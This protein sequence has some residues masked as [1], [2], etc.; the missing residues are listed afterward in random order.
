MIINGIT[1]IN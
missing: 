1:K